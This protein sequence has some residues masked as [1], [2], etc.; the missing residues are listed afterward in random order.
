MKKVKL[1]ISDKPHS[2]DL[3]SLGSIFAPLIKGVA[4]AEDLIEADV[5]FRWR[6]VAG[7]E[8][9]SFS[10]PLK[11]K[12]NPRDNIRTL[13]LEVPFGGY[14]L[15]MQHREEYIIEKINA[16]FGYKA[17]HKLNISQNIRMQ[18]KNIIAPEQKTEEILEKREEEYLCAAVKEIKDEKLKEI[19]IKLGKSVIISNRGTK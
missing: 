15:E 18:P 11:V 3:E 7:S 9:A 10:S 8:L 17:I 14:A 6:E 1:N 19:L 13:Y 16:Y 12:F 2:N 5:M 4:S